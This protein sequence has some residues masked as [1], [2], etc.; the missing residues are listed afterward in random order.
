MSNHKE[1]GLAKY[2]YTKKD[3]ARIKGVKVSTVHNVE[4]I[5]KALGSVNRGVKRKSIQI[6]DEEFAL[7][8]TFMPGIY[9]PKDKGLMYRTWRD[10]FPRFRVF[11]CA[12]YPV[13]LKV[14]LERQGYCRTCGGDGVLGFNGG[15]YVTIRH[16]GKQQPYS[17]IILG[18]L[19]KGMCAYHID[20]NRW[21]NHHSNLRAVFSDE[22]LFP[23]QRQDSPYLDLSY[24]RPEY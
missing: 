10:R 24:R 17:S 2:Y 21:N 22:K 5:D 13:C 18:S 15:G 20:G 1:R 7:E 11:R 14:L 9:G 8:D 3:I 19:P 12:S 6:S 4:T 23:C 16:S